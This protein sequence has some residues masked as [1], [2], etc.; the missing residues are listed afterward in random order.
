MY[1]ISKVK[2]IGCGLCIKDCPFSLIGLD[3]NNKAS[4][5]DTAACNQCGHCF[6]VCPNEA[7][8]T[9]DFDMTEVQPI[10]KES[11][12]L[13]PEQLLSHIKTR[14][15]VRQFTNRTVDRDSLAQ[16]VEAGRYSP[17]GMNVQDVTFTVVTENLDKV[18]E[19][20]YE[21]LN[22]MGTY[23]LG[24]PTKET[25]GMQEFAK[26]WVEQCKLFKETNGEKDFIFR[27]AKALI[28]ASSAQSING[29]IASSNMELM[30]HAL[31]L[32]GYFNYF[33]VMA[34]NE[35]EEIRKLLQIERDK[36][37]ACCLSIGYPNV[38]YKRT[39]PRKPANIKWI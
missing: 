33:F 22:Q 29:T 31:G 7:I 20:T 14:R 2:C 9:D 28:V 6:A 8:E 4:F 27:N 30:V 24:Y 18:K 11:S 13:T 15:S 32:G 17:T 25:E 16:I 38:S 1:T 19:L 39:A 21:T 37:V 12:S 34:A 5:L 26:L 3:E 10:D 35:N 36:T 23:I